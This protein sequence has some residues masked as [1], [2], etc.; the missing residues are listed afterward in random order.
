M[1]IQF[2]GT[3]TPADNR[4]T[5]PYT[6]DVP[7]GVSKLAIFFDFEPL[8]TEGQPYPQQISLAIHDPNG[9]RG[10][11]SITTREGLHIS[12]AGAT[13][14]T[15]PG[16]IPA[17]EWIV[18]VL[19]HRI[20]PPIPVTYRLRVE[21]SSELVTETAPVWTPGTTAPRG[22]GWYRG[23]LHGH[24]IHSDG[25]WDIPE[26]VEYMRSRHLDFV[27]LS[28]H[29]TISGVAQHR[30][31]ANDD[32]VAIGGVE[33]SMFRGHALALGVQQ[34]FDWREGTQRML[35]MPELAQKV[36]DAGAFFV[37]AH[38]MAVGDPECCG[39]HWEFEDMMPGN[40]PAAEVWNGYWHAYN[41][42]SL[43]LYRDW[44]NDGHRMVSTSGTDIH[45][46]PPMEGIGRAAANVVYADAFSETAILEGIRR[47]HSYISAG[48]GL[49]LTARTEAG[50]EAMMG[51]S[52]PAQ[53]VTIVASWDR[54]PEGTTLRVI[55]DGRTYQEQP[56][57]AS[58][59]GSWALER[60]ACGWVSLELR[61][62]DGIPWALTNPL[63]LDGRR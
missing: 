25:S 63:F 58:G 42:E 61:D 38:P 32:L 36:L 28:D 31:L 19:A 24:T 20:Q 21:W 27:T 44:L 53:P 5:I 30:S 7:E 62:A 48:P 14:G 50:Q 45:G 55:A 54:A 6:I 11:W 43:A 10:E 60:G 17:G 37:I 3:L 49:I 52:L 35:S 46:R 41:E 57:E 29:N 39:C 18:F 4:R 40:A 22:P 9:P 16:A 47:G 8:H 1:S 59:A 12:P 56:V 13:P 23:D 15:L 51:D 26:F 34:W 33:L 2:D